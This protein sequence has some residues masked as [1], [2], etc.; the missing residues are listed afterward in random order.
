MILTLNLGVYVR[1]LSEELGR[2]FKSP[3]LSHILLPQFGSYLSYLAIF[4]Y[5]D[6]IFIFDSSISFIYKLLYCYYA[7]WRCQ[8]FS[9]SPAKYPTLHS[10]VSTWPVL[11]QDNSASIF[12]ITQMVV[13]G[14]QAECYP[15]VSTLEHTSNNDPMSYLKLEMIARSLPHVSKLIF[16][17]DILFLFLFFHDKNDSHSS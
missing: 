17:V 6:Q 2:S 1:L 9:C 11:R 16:L 3:P 10:S 15:W 5:I 12:K 4:M 13:G 7:L 8:I 14:I